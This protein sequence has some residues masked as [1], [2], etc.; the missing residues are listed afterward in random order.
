MA[1]KALTEQ[2]PSRVLEIL[3]KE[4]P[5]ER[6]ALGILGALVIVLGVYLVEGRL[7]TIRLT[8]WWIFNTDTKILIFSIFVIAIGAL[9]FFM[10]IWPFFVPS[11]GE[12]KKVTWPGRSMILNHTAR[13]F[14][15]ILSISA[16]F[17]VSDW[18]IRGVQLLWNDHIAG[19]LGL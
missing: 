12:M 7:L 5:F 14:G 3:R 13:V 6:I 2:K 4:Y 1:K 8:N 17:I 19:W 15:F 16:F 11:F 10:A 18:A 9:S